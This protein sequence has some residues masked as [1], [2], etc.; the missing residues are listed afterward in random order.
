[1]LLTLRSLRLPLA[2][3]ATVT[4]PAFAQVG[5]AGAGAAAPGAAATT[6]GAVTTS[7]GIGTT[8]GIATPSPATPG[9]ATTSP[10]S[11]TPAP[12]VTGTSP[13]QFGSSVGSTPTLGN[14][15]GGSSVAG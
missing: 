15:S 5:G 6:P 4:L 14:A 3:L 1:M 2:L 7:P 10:F 8:P 9:A 11:V 12:S 13:S